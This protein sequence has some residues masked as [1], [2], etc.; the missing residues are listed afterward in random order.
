MLATYLRPDYME[1]FQCNG[2]V[3]GS[4]CCRDWRVGIDPV[5]YEKYC[6]L[7][8]EELRRE[9][10][11]W[12]GG[13]DEKMDYQ[14]RL[15]E[16]GRCPYL[17]D[18]LLCHIQR[19]KGEGFLSDICYSYPRVTYRLGNLRQ[20]SLTMSCPVAA[21][22]L[23]GQDHPIRFHTEEREEERS[24]WQFDM[25]ARVRG[26]AGIWQRLQLAGIGFLQDRRHSLSQR[27]LSIL[28]FYRDAEA[29]A[30]GEVGNALRELLEAAEA[31]DYISCTLEKME[32]KGFRREEHVALM[33]E[34]F[35][36]LY[37]APMSEERFLALLSAFVRNDGTFR[38]QVLEAY[39]LPLENYLVNEFF[40][41]FYPFAYGDSLEQNARIFILGWKAVEFALRMLSAQQKMDFD[42]LLL[43]LDRLTER[44]DHNR[45]GMR[46]I[47]A[48]AE[49]MDCEAEEFARVMLD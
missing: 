37:G 17:Q 21:R 16:D 18:D 11:Q 1:N 45:D 10:C 14:V 13:Q 35:H 28:L 39:A 6:A 40:L 48:Q 9:I 29:A 8:P 46:T 4:R 47:R 27:L 38:S 15:R 43:G 24:G 42:R 34:L 12:I 25:A 31:G 2:T 26:Y 36:A 32:G 44:L 33:M 41:R 7:E 20:Q 23:L 19:E 49:A 3:C 30:K 5:T 22:L